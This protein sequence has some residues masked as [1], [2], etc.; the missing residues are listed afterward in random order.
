[1]RSYVTATIGWSGLEK[2]TG[3]HRKSLMRMLAPRRG[4]PMLA[5]FASI[6]LA[7]E[8]HDG[9]RF[10]RIGGNHHVPRTGS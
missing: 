10:K 4:S 5:N 2:A 6:L 3:I 7:L 8:T 1:M 9:V